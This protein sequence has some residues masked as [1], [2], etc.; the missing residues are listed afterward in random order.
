MCTVRPPP[1]LRGLLNDDVFD[2]QV[3]NRQLFRI[4]VGFGVFKE[5]KNISD[6]LLGPSS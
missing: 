3:A 6:R 1:G 5:T 2:D 4:R